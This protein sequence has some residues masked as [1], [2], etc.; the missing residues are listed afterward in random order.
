MKTQKRPVKKQKRPVKI[1]SKRDLL[2]SKRDLLGCQL[3]NKP[4]TRGVMKK[5]KPT[6]MHIETAKNHRV[7]TQK[8]PIKK[9]K[10]TY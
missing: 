7:K 6:K 10:K 1:R 9:Q 3:C 4:F 8:R 5:H 2:R